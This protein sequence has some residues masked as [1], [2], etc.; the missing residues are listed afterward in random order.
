[1][2]RRGALAGIGS[3]L[4]AAMLPWQGRAAGPHQ[5]T[6]YIRTNWSRDP[7]S[8]GSYSYV[9]RGSRQRDRRRLEAPV[10]GRL[11][12]AGEAVYPDYNSTVHA[13]FESG[14]RSANMVLETDAQ[15]I[16][17]VGAGVSG[18]AAAQLLASH[19]RQV[20][21]FE[22]RDRIGGRV[23]TDHRLGVPVDLGASWIHGTTNNPLTWLADQQS[24]RRLRHGDSMVVRGAG[25]R[26]IDENDTPDWFDDV[27]MIEHDA[28]ADADQINYSAYLLQDDYGGPDVV[29]ADGYEAI[30]PGLAGGYETRLSAPVVAVSLG[31]SGVSLTLASA[32]PVE[33]DVVIVTVPLGV[34]KQRRIAFSPALPPEKLDAI[35]RLGMGTLDKLYLAFEEVFWDPDPVWL[36]T[37]EAGLPYGQFVQWLNLHAVLGVPILMAFNGGSPALA[38]AGLSDQEVVARGLQALGVAY[39][40]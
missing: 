4:L 9:A 34:L 38:L 10:D 24:A 36:G 6:G 1:M 20:T 3:G 33:A 14:R 39:P 32:G 5:P 11:F 22:A 17:V 31:P 7:F 37:I 28:G 26:W 8:Y 30:L 15:R 18:L 2:D 16:A 40:G 25:G 13:A 23:W 27:T 29:F 12:F 35:D 19:G 21:V